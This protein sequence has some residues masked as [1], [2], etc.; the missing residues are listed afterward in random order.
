MTM[1]RMFDIV[2]GAFWGKRGPVEGIAADDP[3]YLDVSLA[4]GRKKKLPVETTRST[5]SPY[6]FGG[7]GKILQRF[8]SPRGAYR[9]DEV[10]RYRSTHRSG[11][12]LAGTF[13]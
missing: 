4:P 2:C 10:A 13:R 11:R 7:G 12:P 6:V 1:A 8:W 9:R 5:P 3:I